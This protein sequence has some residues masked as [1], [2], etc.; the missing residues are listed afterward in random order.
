MTTAT[1]DIL[2][3]PV[4]DSAT[5]FTTTQSTVEENAPIGQKPVRKKRAPKHDFKDGRGRVFAHRHANGNGWVSDTAKVSETVYVASCCGVGGTA[6]VEGNVRLEGRSRISGYACVRDYVVLR[7]QAYIHER[8]VVVGN[9]T[10]TDEVNVYGEARIG[11]RTSLSGHAH[12]FGSA[13]IC[14]STIIGYVAIFGETIVIKSTVNGRGLRMNDELRAVRPPPIQT[15]RNNPCLC[16]CNFGH[17]QNSQIHGAGFIYNHAK[18][19]DS[20]IYSLSTQW[21]EIY[22]H[23][24]ILNDS[25]ITTNFK[26]GGDTTI[27]RSYWHSHGFSNAFSPNNAPITVDR[28]QTFIR[29]RITTETEFQRY[30]TENAGVSTATASRNQPSAQIPQL[31]Q[32]TN[33]GPVQIPGFGH[34][35]IIRAD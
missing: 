27:S 32:P 30:A 9:T 13:F 3:Q 21:F 25:N 10:V 12:I 5:G 31:P 29:A 33:T 7:K 8:A 28:S 2:T 1:L 6:Q 26:I 20:Q 18:I 14:E 19:I 34:R 22:G 24:L 16:V 35:R 17:I 15:N 23:A 11:G 4:S